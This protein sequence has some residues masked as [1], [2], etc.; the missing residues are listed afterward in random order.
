M[1]DSMQFIKDIT[2]AIKAQAQSWV[3]AFIL[4]CLATWLGLSSDK[5][6]DVVTT[7]LADPNSFPK[8]LFIFAFIAAMPALREVAS[9]RSRT[10]AIKRGAKRIFEDKEVLYVQNVVTE[11]T[12]SANGNSR[13][14]DEENLRRIRNAYADTKTCK[15][16]L[17]ETDLA[18]QNPSNP[19]LFMI[20]E[21]KEFVRWLADTRDIPLPETW[22]R[23]AWPAKPKGGYLR[24]CT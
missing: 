7:F 15:I 10:M 18:R 8:V 12:K 23:T 4:G 21:K 6:R 17:T 13:F 3:A 11:W 22:Y 20:I 14:N 5:L 2:V 1:Q 24:K 9:N 16:K 19:V